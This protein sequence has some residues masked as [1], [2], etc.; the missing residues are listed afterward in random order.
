MRLYPTLRICWSADRFPERM[1]IQTLKYRKELSRAKQTITIFLYDVYGFHDS[2]KDRWLVSWEGNSAQTR[3]HIFD[4]SATWA[5][6]SWLPSFFVELQDLKT[7]KDAIFFLT[8]A[9]S[10]TWVRFSSSNYGNISC[11]EC[12]SYFYWK[13]TLS[14][15]NKILDPW[16]LSLRSRPYRQRPLI[17]K[18][19]C[20][21]PSLK[22][23]SGMVHSVGNI[24][25]WLRMKEIAQFLTGMPYSPSTYNQDLDFLYIWLCIYLPIIITLLVHSWNTFIN[26]Y[27]MLH[28]CLAFIPFSSADRIVVPL[29]LG[30]VSHRNNEA[31]LYLISLIVVGCWCGILEKHASGHHSHKGIITKPIKTYENHTKLNHSMI[32][33]WTP[34]CEKTNYR[35]G[36]TLVMRA[37]NANC[38]KLVRKAAMISWVLG[39]VLKLT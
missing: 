4:E 29:H 35:P 32:F 16:H 8:N 28:F 33:L 15:S 18:V 12:M 34:G 5:L 19:S 14:Y 36:S 2:D 1:R 22:A 9:R 11:R 38:A 27:S 20:A 7:Q 39:V 25:F 30:C 6:F 17:L 24:L 26:R 23:H 13:W 10:V 31:C 21:A 37:I 3:T